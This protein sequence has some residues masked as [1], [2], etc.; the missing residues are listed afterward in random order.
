MCMY[1]VGWN[2]PLLFGVVVF[3]DLESPADENR[4]PLEDNRPLLKDNRPPL[5]TIVLL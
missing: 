2:G 3:P 5:R 1:G 4:P